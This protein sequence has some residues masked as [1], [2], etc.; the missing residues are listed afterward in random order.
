VKNMSLLL[1]LV[2]VLETFKVMLLGR[3]AR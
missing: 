2:I 3:G 1:D